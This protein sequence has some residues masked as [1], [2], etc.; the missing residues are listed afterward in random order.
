MI[1]ILLLSLGILFAGELEVEGDLKVTGNIQNQTIDSLQ[2][3]I[4]DVQTQVAALQAAG[5]FETRSIH[6]DRIEF[7]GS[8]IQH[9][10]IN[11]DLIN[12]LFNSNVTAAHVRFFNLNDYNFTEIGGGYV[13]IKL[14]HHHQS[15]WYQFQKVELNQNGLI[16]NEPG[17]FA[18]T[19]SNNNIEIQL[20]PNGYTGY[21]DLVFLIT[22]DFSNAPIY[23]A[24]EPPQNSRSAQ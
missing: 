19:D 15:G 14:H 8:Q 12:S 3:V 18:Y 20:E 16:M 22:A 7:S 24:P 5:G 17:N 2:Q 13:D 9:S 23:Q 6:I 11:P 1:R 10:Y 21:V 4:G